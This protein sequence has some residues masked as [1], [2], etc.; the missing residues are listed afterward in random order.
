LD[1]AATAEKGLS[2]QQF[3]LPALL[4]AVTSILALP[5]CQATKDAAVATAKAPLATAQGL[6][7][8]AS[9][10]PDM[11]ALLLAFQSLDPKPIETLSA[12]EARRQPTMADAVRKYLED[13]G[14]STAPMPVAKTR[15]I[16][17]SGPGG[18]IPARIYTPERAGREP[19]PVVV[20]YH[21]GGWVTAD[22][23]TYDASQRAIANGAGAIVVGIDYRRGPE[24]KFPAAHEDAFA[25]YQWVLENARS[26][27]GDPKRVATVGESAGGGLAVATALLARQH[28]TA[29]PVHV[30]AIYAIAGTNTDTPSYVE[31]ANAKPLNKPM[32]AWFFD[33][34]LRG[35]ADY[36]ESLIDLVHAPGLAGLPPTTIVTA[37][38]D[39]LRSE[40]QM[41][42]DRLRTAGVAVEIRD[43]AGVTHEFFGTAPIVTDST[44][45]QAFVSDQLRRAFAPGS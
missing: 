15:D 40:G 45:A 20:Y 21:G 7:T 30:V 37:E 27:G 33:H 31:N 13:R 14:E 23:D 9:A 3:R 25:A 4:V 2:V 8:V 11:A 43:Y 32:M 19:L 24:H 36:Q 6:P 12:E 28:G 18:P 16:A 34:Y 35:P 38:I 26:F 1:R 10:D 22:I 39:P 44:A 42:A 5:A 29:A 41:L 17:I